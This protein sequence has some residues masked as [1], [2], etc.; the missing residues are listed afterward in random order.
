MANLF[1]FSLFCIFGLFFPPLLFFL[2]ILFSC[3]AIDPA[4][5]LSEARRLLQAGKAAE[6]AAMLRDLREGTPGDYAIEYELARAEHEAGNPEAAA[7]AVAA[8]IQADPGSLDA[9]LLRGIILGDLGRDQEALAEL[10]QVVAGAPERPGVH[11]TMG[12]I[13]YKIGQM[14]L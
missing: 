6:A 1:L 13:H 8:A 5:G 10:R 11:R 14:H 4:V 2:P 9:R 7:V 12:L 3:K